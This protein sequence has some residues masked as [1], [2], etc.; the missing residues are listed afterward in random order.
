V[1]IMASTYPQDLSRDVASAREAVTPPRP[2]S[3]MTRLFPLLSRGRWY[4]A[5]LAAMPPRE[6]PHR[7]AQAR[8]CMMW[9]RDIAGWLAFDAIGDGPLADLAPLRARLSRSVGLG[10]DDPSR[11]SRRRTFDGQFG[12]LGFDW[13]PVAVE[14]GRALQIPSLFWFHDPITGKSWPDEETSSFDID[15]R[16]TGAQIGDVKYVWE[17][18]RLQMLHPL[19]AAMAAT[20]DRTARQ[21][22]FSVLES[23]AAANPP[24]R[25]VNWVSG[26]ELALRLVSIMLVVAAA[27][28][29]TLSFG[30]RILIRRL[31]VAH[32]RYLAA[33][34][35]LYSSANNH[36]V[37]EG[38]GLFIAGALLPDLDEARLWLDDGRAI[39]EAESVRQI[40][41]DG[42]GAEQSPTYQAF[43]MEMLALAARLA[44]DLRAPLDAS[45][46]ERLVRGAEYLLWLA[47]DNGH[48]PAI[49]DDDEGRVIAQPPDRE[50]RYVVSVIAAV[51]GL[52][53][54]SDLAPAARDP[55]LRDAIFDSPVTPSAERTGLRI[56]ER[57]GITV[58][59][60]TIAGR[61]SHLVFDHGPLGLLPLAAHGHA[62]ALA[63]WLTI[64]GQPVF[65][66]AGTYRY[67][68]GGEVRTELRESLAHNTLA[69]ERV[70]HSRA[71]T[72]FGWS[73]KAN[74]SLV[75]ASHGPEW[76]VTAA[77]DGYRRRFGVR[78]IR[79]VSRTPTGYAVEDRLDGH[80]RPLPVGLRYLCHPDVTVAIEGGTV[81]IS[82]KSGLLC[83]ITP[84][85]GF[86]VEIGQTLHSQRFGHVAPAPQL[87]FAGQLADDAAKTMIDIAEPPTSGTNAEHRTAHPAARQAALA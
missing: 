8:R 38:L 64:D 47:G 25:G 71:S 50:P 4:A 30:E 34:P 9:R 54:R 1:A 78:H 58:A 36:R 3:R 27:E 20:Q 79:Q 39:L 13:P 74:A 43:T 11:I 37:A 86:S 69:I 21:I 81:T 63:I 14:Q 6:V 70:S 65:I 28:P 29:S 83:R 80:N 82:G 23:W 17:P 73:T 84:P 19:A 31:V 60:E 45:V 10:A 32:A 22:A 59:N 15:V 51:A 44:V 56:S 77:H 53:E 87:V 16:S 7:I 52:A 55:H 72:A 62:D 85:K 35:S 48:V 41:A 12:F 68:S 24:Y 66:D 40:L 2:R 5:R 42:V 46:T 18:N 49:G 57:G 33:F 76:W 75:A 67:F 26:I 61:R